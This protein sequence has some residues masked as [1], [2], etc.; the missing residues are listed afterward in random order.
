[1]GFPILSS[2]LTDAF[3]Q[4]EAERKGNIVM[5]NPFVYGEAVSGEQFCNRVN[6]IN[7]LITDIKNGLNIIIFSPGR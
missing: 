6:E 3:L 4:S 1:M 2:Y 5:K 7:E